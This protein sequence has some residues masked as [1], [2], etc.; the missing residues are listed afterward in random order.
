MAN[1]FNRKKISIFKTARWQI[2]LKRYVDFLKIEIL[3]IK[4]FNP[5]KLSGS[6]K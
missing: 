2:P 6:D 4:K 5:E 3:Q 1:M